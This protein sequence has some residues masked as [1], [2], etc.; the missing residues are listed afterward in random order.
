MDKP[1]LAFLRP[2]LCIVVTLGVILSGS[3]PAQGQQDVLMT[4]TPRPEETTGIS[5]L[6]DSL[7]SAVITGPD[8]A[9]IEIVRVPGMPP[10][11]LKAASAAAVPSATAV[12]IPGMPAYI[13]SFGCSPTVAAMMAAWYDNNG[14]PNLY[15]GPA[16]GGSAPLNNLGWGT[17][18]IAGSRE[19][20]CPL[21]A[22]MNGLDG[23]TSRGHVDDYYTE[24]LSSARDP[25]LVN[26]WT[27]HTPPDCTADFMGTSQS[28]YDNVDGSTIFYYYVDN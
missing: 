5:T 1:A 21:S 6:P 2:L 11:Q 8:E 28:E 7:V 24:Y 4:L 14:Y 27:E 22:S 20:L 13:W 18:T 9:P 26:N 23:R 12:I 16:N 17:V 15:T 19:N 25:Y 3:L 10:R